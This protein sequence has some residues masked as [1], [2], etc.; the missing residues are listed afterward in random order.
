MT[1]AAKAQ[2]PFWPVPMTLHTMAVMAFAVLFGPRRAIAIFAAY[3][4]AGAIGLPV[5]SGTPERGVGLAYM[6]GPTG[7]YLLGYL[8]ASGATGMLASGRGTIGQVVAMLAGLTIVYAAGIAWLAAFVPANRLLELGVWPFLPGDLL[9][10]AIVAFA[11]R[12]A[13]RLRSAHA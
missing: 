6:I 8:L 9:K 7:G 4:G 3:L 5:F 1:L 11:L 2:V 12:F 10:I 13:S